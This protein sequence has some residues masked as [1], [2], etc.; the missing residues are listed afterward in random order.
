MSH[1]IKWGEE[2]LSTRDIC[3][4]EGISEY[5]VY[6][7]MKRTGEDPKTV[8]LYYLNQPNKGNREKI[9]LNGEYLDVK[10]YCKQLNYD[11]NLV[12]RYKDS[13][14]NKSYTEVL[15]EWENLTED[16]ILN[17][18]HLY[19]IWCNMLARCENPKCISYKYYGG[20]KPK[21]VTVCKEWHDYMTFRNQVWND[22]IEHVEQYG[23]EQTTLDRKKT[24]YNYSYKECQ[25][26]DWE[27]QGRNT[28]K[29]KY[30]LP[31]KNYQK[32]LSQHCKQNGYVYIT[33][34]TYI[35][36]YN[37]TPDKALAKYLKEMKNE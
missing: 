37:L 12:T 31:C 30:I 6:N 18:I 14:L 1:K 17:N 34:V 27:Q 24:W 23:R 7:R 2:I 4:K 25:W 29:T 26:A 20:K 9:E 16:E 10:N 35:K 28:S 32:T 5:A 22:Y 11:Y 19:D 21:P 13:Q 33:I 8:L 3:K 15:K 36:K